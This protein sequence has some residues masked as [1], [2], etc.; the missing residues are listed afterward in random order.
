VLA[1]PPGFEKSGILKPLQ[2]TLNRSYGLACK[3]SNLP[4]IMPFAG[5]KEKQLED[6]QS[7]FGSEKGFQD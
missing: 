3:G 1:L 7:G 6:L 4:H 5:G 2:L